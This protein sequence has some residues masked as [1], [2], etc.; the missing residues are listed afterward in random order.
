VELGNLAVELGQ[1]AAWAALG[2]VLLAVGYWVVDLLTPGRLGELLYE[3]HNVNAG[4]VVASGLLAIGAIVTTAIAAS[5]DGFVPGL[6]SALAYGGLG[7]AVLAVSFV[8]TD[9][10][11]PGELGELVTR[12]EPNPAA[13]IVAAN[14]V[15]LG[16]IICAA[17]A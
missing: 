17:I 9:R 11:T 12:T 5:L 15:A 3:Q 13:W 2:I 14:H 6:L 8:I 4:V 10:I 16:A 7:I 1:I